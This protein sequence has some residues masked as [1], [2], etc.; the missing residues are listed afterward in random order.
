MN[1]KQGFQHILFLLVIIPVALDL[2]GRIFGFPGSLPVFAAIPLV[3]FV[4]IGVVTNFLSNHACSR[5]ERKR[6]QVR[7]L[8]NRLEQNPRELLVYHQGRSAVLTTVRVEDGKYIVD[9]N[10]QQRSIDRNVLL[11]SIARKGRSI[12]QRKGLGER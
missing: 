6:E 11:N 4:M 7:S 1:S 12:R 3:L 5:A 8:L 10:G 9:R 2:A